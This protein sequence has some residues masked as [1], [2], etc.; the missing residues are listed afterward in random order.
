[1]SLL[2]TSSLPGYITFDSSNNKL[3]LK[4]NEE[5]IVVVDVKLIDEDGKFSNWK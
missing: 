4:P 2:I 5:D 3:L 1:M